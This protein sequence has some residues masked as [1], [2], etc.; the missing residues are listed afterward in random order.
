[1]SESTDHSGNPASPLDFIG[2]DEFVASFEGC[3]LPNSAFHHADHVRMAF[4]Y[5]SRFPVLQALQRFSAALANF[6]AANG[7]PYLYN[8]TITW[9]FLLLIRER[10]ARAGNPQNWLQFAAANPDLLNWEGNILK[11]YYREET[12]KSDLA[13]TT[14]IFPDKSAAS[15]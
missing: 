11:Q 9:A 3:T 2:D 8:E 7:K 4:L 6:A 10:I 14:F 5:I 15:T 12:L 1:M 13:R